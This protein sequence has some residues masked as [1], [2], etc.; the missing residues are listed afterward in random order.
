MRRIRMTTP[1]TTRNGVDVT[2][3]GIGPCSLRANRGCGGYDQVG[4]G[5]RDDLDHAARRYLGVG[6]GGHVVRRAGEADEDAAETIGWDRH[7]DPA[8]RADHVL[9]AESIGGLGLAKKPE[10]RQNDG[11]ADHS[12][13]DSDQRRKADPDAESVNAKQASDSKHGDKAEEDGGWRNAAEVKTEM[14]GVQ[15]PAQQVVEDQGQQ[16]QAAPD[17]E[18]STEYEIGRA[19]S[20]STSDCILGRRSAD[21]LQTAQ[22]RVHKAFRPRVDPP[23]RQHLVHDVRERDTASGIG[24][25]HR[26]T[27]PVVAERA[28]P[29]HRAE[30]ERE[31]EAGRVTRLVAQDEILAGGLNAGRRI[32]CVS[33]QQPHAVYLADAGGIH[34]RKRARIGDAVGGGDLRGVKRPLVE[35]RGRQGRVDERPVEQ[36]RRIEE[37]RGEDVE[38]CSRGWRRRREHRRHPGLHFLRQADPQ[39]ELQWPADSLGD[40]PSNRNTGD[41]A[42]HLAR[43]PS[44][45]AHVIAMGGVRLPEWTLGAKALDDRCPSVDILDADR[46]VDRRKPSAVAE[47]PSHR[48]LVLALCP[49]LRPVFDDGR[50]EVELALLRQ[51]VPGNRNHTLGRR[52]DHLQ[53]VCRV[54][55]RG[56]WAG[57]AALE[58]DDGSAIEIHAAG[59]TNIAESLE[60]SRESIAY[61]LETGLHETLGATLD[62]AANVL[63]AHRLP[64]PRRSRP[65]PLDPG[66]IDVLAASIYRHLDREHADVNQGGPQPPGQQSDECSKHSDH[67]PYDR[68]DE[69]PAIGHRLEGP[70]LVAEWKELLGNAEA[71]AELR[72]PVHDGTR[73][74]AD[75]CTERGTREQAEDEAGDGAGEHCAP[76]GKPH[77]KVVHH[78]RR[79]TRDK[80]SI[81]ATRKT[82]GRAK[83]YAMYGTRSECRSLG[84]KAAA[85]PLD[86]TVAGAADGAVRAHVRLAAT[87]ALRR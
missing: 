7:R 57:H 54:R 73:E 74:P 80:T 21:R 46:T 49:E 38:R 4:A 35:D 81:T 24:E 69:K 30:R 84:S 32:H 40:E 47:Q 62:H 17:K 18:A 28:F 11:G 50:V 45:R 19:H 76:D 68:D 33:L 63:L 3:S 87:P 58:I 25:T 72:L 55:L 82:A 37:A 5:D 65:A 27:H 15:E 20:L 9:E 83:P 31:L 79:L 51:D 78:A 36:R 60:V 56:S 14:E 42:D 43:Q 39:V 70:D 13:H 67:Q 75:Q 29:C 10:R 12:G 52:H 59:G 64:P 22:E 8:G 1:A 85:T 26:P 44:V 23:G 71:E 6:G 86:L 61:R 77:Q 16:Q 41:A 34:P 66:C 2:N 53:G 48:D